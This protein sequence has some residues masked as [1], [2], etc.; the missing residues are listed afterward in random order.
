MNIIKNLNQGTYDVAL[1]GKFTFGDHLAFR[2]ILQKIE[3]KDVSKIVLHLD[4]L[5]FIDSAALGMLLLALDVSE[6][7][8]KQLIISGITG[9]VKKIF[10]LARFHTLFAMG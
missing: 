1:N 9:Q 2:E 10:E 5:E 6:K 4:H 7:N 8:H 3:E